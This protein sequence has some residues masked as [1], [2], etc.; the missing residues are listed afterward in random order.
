V[1][2]AAPSVV[3]PPVPPGVP[4]LDAPVE[5]AAPAAGVPAPE[6]G[7]PL[8]GGVEPGSMEGAAAV[9]PSVGVPLVVG[10]PA[11]GEP[12]PPPEESPV[13]PE[14]GWQVLARLEVV[15]GGVA[16]VGAPV[17]SQEL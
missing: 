9:E 13:A 4:V 2:G 1:G 6:G 7:L 15:D 11:G 17:A 12:P 16:V 14:L 5:P 3:A 10:P 8:G